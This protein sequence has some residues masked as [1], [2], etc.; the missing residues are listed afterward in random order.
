[1]PIN[2][3]LNRI[4]DLSDEEAKLVTHITEAARW[5]PLQGP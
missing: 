1:V 2:E 4:L 3:K 5:L